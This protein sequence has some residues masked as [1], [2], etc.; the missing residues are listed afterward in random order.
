M[1]GSATS[2]GSHNYTGTGNAAT[3]NSRG[4]LQQ[5]ILGPNAAAMID[6][7]QST[8]VIDDIVTRQL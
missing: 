8:S 7:S 2:G 3:G 6:V 4:P 5:M 1:A